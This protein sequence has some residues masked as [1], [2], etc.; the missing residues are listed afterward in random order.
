MQSLV[1][2]FV[3]PS[4]K[5]DTAELEKVQK[6]AT[7]MIERAGKPSIK[8]VHDVKKVDREKFL[9]RFHNSRTSAEHSMKLLRGTFRTDRRR[10]CFS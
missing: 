8:N 3:S 5:K 1:D 9:S 7:K 2:R 6:T 4:L 10:W